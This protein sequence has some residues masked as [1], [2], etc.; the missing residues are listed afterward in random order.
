VPATT[1]T[2][3]KGSAQGT[4]ARVSAARAAAE[5][6]H[7]ERS[8]RAKRAAA[9]RRKRREAAEKEANAGKLTAREAVKVVLPE[10]GRPMHYREISRAMVERGIVKVRRGATP[11]QTMKTV[12]SFLAGEVQDETKDAEFVRLEPGVFDLKK[13]PRARKRAAAKKS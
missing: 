7:Q 12:R 10:A 2:K 9:T 1:K 3:T 4:R 11:E 5:I 13:R 6:E 8:E